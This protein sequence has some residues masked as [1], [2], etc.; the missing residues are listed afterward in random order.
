[1]AQTAGGAELSRERIATETL[2][3]YTGSAAAAFQPMILLT[4]FQHYVDEFAA[5]SGGDRTDGSAMS[6][7]HDTKEKVSIIRFGI[8][9]PNAAL[10]MDLLS[11]IK[12]QAVVF[13]G[14]CGGLSAK[15]HVGDFFLPSA[16]IRDEGTSRHYLPER[17]PAMPY[18]HIHRRLSLA[19]D[20]RKLNY[21]HG[22]IHTTNYRFW[23]FDQQFREGLIAEKAKAIDMECATLFSVAFAREVRV[24]ALLLIS[25]LPLASGGIKTKDSSQSIFDKYTSLHLE[26][27]S[28]ALSRIR[29]DVR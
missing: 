16:A 26:V 28:E 15:H 12:P 5:R 3:R 1:L 11:F 18:F 25:D 22:I 6:A 2:E 19:L 10:I 17:V 27:G 4:N 21:R 29:D 24:G 14:L 9:S 23:E 13:L 20:S 7:A 8:G